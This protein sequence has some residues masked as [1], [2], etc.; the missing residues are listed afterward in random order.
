MKGGKEKKKDEN[1]ISIGK[2]IGQDGAEAEAERDKS[3]KARNET[4]YIQHTART[5]SNATK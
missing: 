5:N 1:N 4:I 2:D 3:G